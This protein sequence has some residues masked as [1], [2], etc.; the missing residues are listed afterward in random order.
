MIPH[1]WFHPEFV[2]EAGT[3]TGEEVAVEVEG[4]IVDMEME[5]V[6]PLKAKH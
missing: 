1:R 5:K 3:A 6:Q 2:D 4:I